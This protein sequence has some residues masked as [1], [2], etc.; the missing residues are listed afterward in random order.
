MTLAA[1][2]SG[3]SLASSGRGGPAAFLAALTRA[4]IDDP[5]A[6]IAVLALLRDKTS[7]AEVRP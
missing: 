3:P 4:V 5:K 2:V 1:C 7:V 6:V